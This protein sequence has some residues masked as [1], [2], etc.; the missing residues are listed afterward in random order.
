KSLHEDYA[1][2]PLTLGYCTRAD[3]PFYYAL[4]DAFTICDQHFCS[5][6]T[7]TL[8]NRLYF[9]TG[10]VRE[11]PTVD[12]PANVRNEQIINNNWKLGWKTFPERLEDLGISWKFYQNEL[13]IPSG[14]GD[15]E[16]AWLGNFGCNITEYF[17]QYH[18]AAHPLHRAYME[19]MRYILP[20]KL[21]SLR[22][23]LAAKGLSKEETAKLNKEL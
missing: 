15:E 23:Q 2:M 1:R 21:A 18:A 13:D 14:L 3:I 6:L 20:D 16:D 22:K 7:P 9:W 5:S 8:P 11:R 12:S 17:R 10:T 4:A 19:K